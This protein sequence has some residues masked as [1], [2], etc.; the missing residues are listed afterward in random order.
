MARDLSDSLANDLDTMGQI[1]DMT[2]GFVRDLVHRQIPHIPEEHLDLLLDEWIPERTEGPTEDSLP[3]D[4]L[5]AMI[6]QFVDFSLG[7]MSSEFIAE[8]QEGWQRR[9]WSVFSERTRTLIR[10]LLLGSL[11]E[12]DFW[13]QVGD[14]DTD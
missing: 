11:P 8:L 2:R 6:V 4:V 9:Y 10:E 1:K 13:E 5:Q 12:E 14:R 3:P 7:R